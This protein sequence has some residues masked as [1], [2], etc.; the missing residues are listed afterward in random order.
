MR[1]RE[2]LE[3]IKAEG[4]QHRCS[5]CGSDESTYSIGQMAKRIAAVFEE[6]YIR[7]TDQPDG[8][9]QSLLSDPELSY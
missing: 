5:Y 6:H 7:T 4:P 2:I 9:E 8:F 1:R 3:E